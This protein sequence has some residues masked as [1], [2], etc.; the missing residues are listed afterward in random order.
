MRLKTLLPKSCLIMFVFFLSSGTFLS[1]LYY[2]CTITR[3]FKA[4]SMSPLEISFVI[5]TSVT[6]T[7]QRK[8]IVC[9]S[10]VLLFVVKGGRV[11]QIFH[12]N[13]ADTFRA[14]LN[15][16][17]SSEV[18]AK[19]AV[20]WEERKE[21]E[22]ELVSLNK[23]IWWWIICNFKMGSSIWMLNMLTNIQRR[24]RLTFD[25]IS[26]TLPEH[27]PCEVLTP[28]HKVSH[29]FLCWHLNLVVCCMRCPVGSTFISTPFS[30]SPIAI[31]LRHMLSIS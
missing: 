21:V 23:A 26:G 22:S 18:T 8:R 16:Q 20:G 6:G 4:K 14:E 10:N 19:G 24:A 12:D 7:P 3:K 28:V 15:L 17:V 13:H 25:F 2:V 31:L 1:R 9:S 29:R 27:L 5:S 11:F 30:Y